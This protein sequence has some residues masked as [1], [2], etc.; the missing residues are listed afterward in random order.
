MRKPVYSITMRDI[1][2]ET[3][4]S[5]GAIYRYFKNVH[6]ILFELMNR[7]TASLKVKEEA[8]RILALSAPAEHIIVE[9]MDLFTRTIFMNTKEFGKMVFE[10]TA[11]IADQPEYIELFYKN[12]KIAADLQYLQNKTF[13]FLVAR[14][15]DGCFKP[16]MPVQDIFSFAGRTI[17]GIQRD[18]TLAQNC[19]FNTPV[20]SEINPQKLM[21]VLCKSL[22]YLLGGDPDKEI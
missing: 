9:I 15:D 18:L 7:Q 1:I 21:K 4:W 11:F 14:I 5:Q 3:G 8:D 12:V 6:L 22:I 13:E 2:A 17:D 19:S 16:L 20:L 10:Y